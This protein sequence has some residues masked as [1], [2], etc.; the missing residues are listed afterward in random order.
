MVNGPADTVAV[1]PLRAAP[2]VLVITKF[3]CPLLPTARTPKSSDAGETSSCGG[4]IPTPVTL[5]VRLP[6]LLVNSTTLLKE[7][8]TAGLKATITWLVWPGDT[9]N[10]VPPTM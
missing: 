5:L 6:P 3:A 7:P 1:P 8:A 10:G 2:P 4:V 9:L